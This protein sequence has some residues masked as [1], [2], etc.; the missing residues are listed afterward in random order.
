MMKKDS[1]FVLLPG[2]GMSAW[3]WSRLVP[4]LNRDVLT[5]E[6]RLEA[7]TLANRTG[8]SLNDLIDYHAGLIEKTRWKRV[9]LVGHSGAGALAA[10]LAK[11][12]PDKTEHVFYLAGNIPPHGKSALD[13]LP[14]FLRQMNRKAILNQI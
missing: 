14:F 8:A 11:W 5:P 3:V 2:G 10:A 9:V 12:L 4:L 1:G 13:A 7:N 6:W